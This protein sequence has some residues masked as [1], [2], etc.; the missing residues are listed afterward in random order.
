MSSKKWIS[1]VF[2]ML[3][4]GMSFMA[5]VNYVVD[6]FSIFGTDFFKQKTQMNERYVKLEYIKKHHNEFNGY[7]FGSSRIGVVKPEV[8]EKYIPNSHFYNFTLSSANLHDYMMHLKFFLKE[9]YVIKT[10]YLQID[11]DDMYCYGQDSTDYLSKLHPDV[12]DESLFLYKIKYLLGFF[13]LNLRTKIELNLKGYSPKSYDLKTGIWQLKEN[14]KAL[15]K[16][17]VAYVKNEK[18]FHIKNRPIIHFSKQ[19]ESMDA[20]KTIVKLCKEHHIKLYIFTTPHNHNKVDIF[21]TNDY[22]KYLRN[23]SEITSFYDFSGY[24]SV[25]NN[26]K[27]YYEMSHY[28]PL[29]GALVAGRI[30]NDTSVNI[31]KDFGK[32]IKKGSLSG[33]KQ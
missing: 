11:L 13:P 22:K 29:V 26:D 2:T 12:T 9:H 4:T 25:T 23:I 32:Y 17:A 21:F 24:N 28:R 3:F 15:Q 5:L 27:N 10:L 1:I 16:D 14:E 30:F 19:K 7:M 31:P 18:S 8:I 20:L 6:P 33:S